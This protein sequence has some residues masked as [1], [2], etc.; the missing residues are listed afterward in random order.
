[1]R[2]HVEDGKPQVGDPKSKPR[3]IRQGMR[4]QPAKA[5]I[6]TEAAVAVIGLRR[7]IRPHRARQ[8]LH[9]VMG[10]QTGG[11]K[12]EVADAA[13]TPPLVGHDTSLAITCADR[14]ANSTP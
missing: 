7:N 12:V 11:M 10:L 1:M 14:N 4:H 2:M 8:P 6:P 13:D 5:A 3:A 9:G